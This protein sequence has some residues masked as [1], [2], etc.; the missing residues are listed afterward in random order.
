MYDLGDLAPEILKPLFVEE[1]KDWNPL[2]QP[3]NFLSLF[4][5]WRRIL[6]GDNPATYS[7]SIAVRDPYHRLVWEVWLPVIRGF[8]K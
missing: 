4:G 2:L 8:I 3:T 1:M 5:R 6:E 7:A